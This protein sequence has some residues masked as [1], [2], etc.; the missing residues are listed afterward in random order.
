MASSTYGMDMDRKISF[1]HEDM[2]PITY[3]IDYTARLALFAA[4]LYFPGFLIGQVWKLRA[5]ELASHLLRFALGAGVWAYGV[6]A[7]AAAGLLSSRAL[8]AAVWVSVFGLVLLVG[9]QIPAAFKANLRRLKLP[10]IGG[11][12]L[13][14]GFL[15]LLL[16]VFLR[17]ILLEMSHDAKVYHLNLPRIYLESGGFTYIANS[18]YSHWPLNIEMIYTA[19]LAFDGFVLAKAV[20][21]LFGLAAFAVL[22]LIAKRAGRPEAGLIAS[23]LLIAN[24]V[25]QIELTIAYVDVAMSFFLL[26]AFWQMHLAIEN[27]DRRRQHLILAGMLTGILAG[28]KLTGFIGGILLGI[29]YLVGTIKE[30]RRVRRFFE[31][32]LFFGLPG[33]LLLAPWLIK[34]TIETGNPVHPF[35]FNLFGGI[36]WNERLAQHAARWYRLM[37]MGREPLDY[38]LLPYRVIAEGGRGFRFF[39]GKTNP[40][41]F[42]MIPIALFS[43]RR[44][45]F[46]RRG[47]FFSL[48]FFVYWA[49]SVQQ[50]RFLIPM[51]PILSIAAAISAVDM[52]GGIERGSIRAAAKI[53]LAILIVGSLLIHGIGMFTETGIHKGAYA[54]KINRDPVPKVFKVIDKDLPAEAKLLLL[55]TMRGYFCHRPYIADSFYPVSQ[56][57]GLHLRNRSL[58]EIA[59]TFRDMG[60]THVLWGWR[61]SGIK[62]PPSF[63]A[64]FD[65]PELTRELFKDRRYHLFEVNWDTVISSA[66][67][68]EPSS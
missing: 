31:M 9:T 27:P 28:C 38:L 48:L 16:T 10:S 63:K 44:N 65:N 3:A 12:I 40:I 24:R 60:I 22:F 56:I 21:F 67:A 17:A 6:F 62:Y 58:E 26:L 39:D 29:V 45:T 49:F 64:I 25:V 13:W 57:Y 2:D 66:T 37:G 15:A 53:L 61:G 35:L 50:M 5:P 43:I 68:K 23:A 11:A 19:A 42:L 46:V 54:R 7:L 59:R 20:H 32:L 14:A 41:W 47:L 33:V 52:I 51:L 18:V 55:D 36:D 4:A 8:E 30:D 1:R 34:S